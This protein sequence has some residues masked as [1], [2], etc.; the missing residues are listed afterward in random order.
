VFEN[1]GASATVLMLRTKSFVFGFAASSNRTRP[2]AIAPGEVATISPVTSSP[3]I[4]TGTDANSGTP[5]ADCTSYTCSRYSPGGTLRKLNVPFAAVLAGATGA[6][7]TASAATS[8]TEAV[9]GTLKE[10]NTVPETTA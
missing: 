1:V 2:L 4:E 5:A 10:L 7:A 9:A 8:R 3:V 6:S